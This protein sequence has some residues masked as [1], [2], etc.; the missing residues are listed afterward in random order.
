MFPGCTNTT[1][2]RASRAKGQRGEREWRKWLLNNLGCIFARRGWQTR[3]GGM[4]EPDVKDG[5][6]GT[7]P[8]VKRVEKLNIWA[9]MAQAEEDAAVRGHIPYTAF[10]RNRGR[11][12]VCTPADDLVGLSVAVVKQAL[13]GGFLT[14]KDILP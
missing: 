9:A 11:W 4:E 13:D 2:G 10:R 12:Y 7:H 6:P 8:E 14:A 3:G 1:M 5:I